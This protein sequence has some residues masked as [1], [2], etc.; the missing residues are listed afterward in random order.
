MAPVADFKSCEFCTNFFFLH[1]L[2]MWLWKKELWLWWRCPCLPGSL[3]S[4][5]WLSNRLN[6]PVDLDLKGG[7]WACE[8][9]KCTILRL[10]PH[11]EQL[12]RKGR[13]E[14]PPCPAGTWHP[15]SVPS[16]SLA[17]I[18]AHL[19]SSYTLK[20]LLCYMVIKSVLNLLSNNNS[21]V[22]FKF[23]TIPTP[24]DSCIWPLPAS[25][26][27]FGLWERALTSETGLNSG[28]FC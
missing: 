10:H 6:A 27:I 28:L 18:F 19:Q 23:K 20:P 12:M 26:F 5:V 17:G 24:P 21:C 9:L 22:F 13:Q 1:Q 25:V 2:W 7:I 15:G 3:E 14:T 11:C 8:F 4:P 16:A